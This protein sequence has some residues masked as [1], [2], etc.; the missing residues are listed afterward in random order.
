M[1]SL[2]P[3]TNIIDLDL[4]V[5]AKKCFRF[6]KDDSRIVYLN[7]SDMSILS[8]MP[9]AYEKL[10]ELEQ[11]AS[12]LLSADTDSDEAVTEVGKNLKEIDDTMRGI[13]D[14]LFDAPVCAAAA[15]NGSMYDPF[16]GQFR[17]EHII[18]VLISQ[19]QSNLQAEYKKVEKQIKSHT[20]KY[21]KRK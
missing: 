20:E 19:Y 14:E 1:S 21:N 15:P 4:S 10:A 16:N 9:T 13:I 6:D 18:S 8:R 7:T 17:F 3:E 12:K 11:S 5:T 2:S